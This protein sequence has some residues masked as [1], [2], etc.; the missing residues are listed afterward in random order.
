MKKTK[1]AK[2]AEPSLLDVTIRNAIAI[3]VLNRPELDHA[4]NDAMI[5]E[6]TSTLIALDDDDTIRAIVLAGAG[7]SFCAG[8]DLNWMKK[9]ATYSHDDN[10]ADA[11]ALAQ[12]LRT[13]SG[14]A[15]PTIAR[16][17]GAAMG[18]GAGL[19]VC[20]DIAIAA[21]EATFAFSEGK[22]GL[23]PATIGP[24][25]IEAIGARQARRYFLTAERFTAAEAFRIGLVHDIVPAVELDARINELLGSLFLVGPRA[26][27]ECKALIRGVAHRPIDAKLIAGTAEHNA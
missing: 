4:V 21:Q 8:A 27:L 17:H 14:L 5:A 16:V 19:V 7:K 10:V 25:V 9:M 18:G 20:C 1:L 13:L 26:Q 15:K 11:T 6:L 2:R 23:I 22:L 3:V 12:M 24:Y